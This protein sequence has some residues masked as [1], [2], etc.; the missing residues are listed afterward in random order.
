MLL[1][2]IPQARRPDKMDASH[3]LELLPKCDILIADFTFA[4]ADGATFARERADAVVVA[5]STLFNDHPA[6]MADL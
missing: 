2:G 4:L 3:L 5:P 1:V 6:R